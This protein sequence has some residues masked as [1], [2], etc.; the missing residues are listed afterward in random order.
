MDRL[1]LHIK[2]RHTRWSKDHNFL[3]RMLPKIFQKRRLPRPG[4]AGTALPVKKTFTELLSNNS[5]ARRNWGLRSR[6]GDLR[7]CEKIFFINKDMLPGCK[8]SGYPS[9]GAAGT[10]L[11]ITDN[12]SSSIFFMSLC[13]SSFCIKSAICQ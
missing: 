13:I 12:K 8:S 1:T 11:F 3:F 10:T 7:E 5:K 9:S 4:K 6:I 2:R